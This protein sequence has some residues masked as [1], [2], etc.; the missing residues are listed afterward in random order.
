MCNP[1]MVSIPCSRLGAHCWQFA[2]DREISIAHGP[3]I[4]CVLSRLLSEFLLRTSSCLVD[5]QGVPPQ[6]IPTSAATALI[7]LATGAGGEQQTEVLSHIVHSC[8]AVAGVAGTD[9]KSGTAVRVTKTTRDAEFCTSCRLPLRR[10]CVVQR[11]RMRAHF[12]LL[13][14][15]SREAP[16]QVQ[17]RCAASEA[18]QD[19]AALVV[20]DKSA[21][22]VL[23]CT[24]GS[25]AAEAQSAQWLCGEVEASQWQATT[26]PTELQACARFE[27]AAAERIQQFGAC[28]AISG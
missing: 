24:L 5:T 14:G 6:G 22:G 3:Q 26:P 21:C 19:F 10:T 28:L 18:A 2:C 23:S 13:I 9:M 17:L 12:A 25:L 11:D 16:L 4:L 20:T 7:Q 15:V 8:A 1:V 27:R